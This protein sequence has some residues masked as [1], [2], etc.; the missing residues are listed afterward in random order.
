[1]VHSKSMMAGINAK[2][3]GIIMRDYRGADGDMKYLSKFNG[4][5]GLKG[6]YGLDR[7]G[8]YCTRQ[9]MS[10]AYSILACRVNC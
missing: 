7:I 5:Y 10:S 1:M 2:Y 4:L 8:D 6:G 3:Q 9:A